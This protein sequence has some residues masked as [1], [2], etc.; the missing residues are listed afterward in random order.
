MA[1]LF[2]SYSR[3]DKLTVRILS[4]N[5]RRIYGHDNVWYD[6]SLAG[7]DIWWEEILDQI[8][9]CDVFLYLLS[10]ESVTSAYCQSE[11]AEAQRLHKRFI[12]IQIRG[13]TRMTPELGDVQYV[14]MTAGPDDAQ[15]LARLV[16]SINEQMEKPRKRRSKIRGRTRRPETTQT[17]PEITD[18]QDSLTLDLRPPKIAIESRWKFTETQAII[19]IVF[20]V[21]SLISVVGL[22]IT[23]LVVADRSSDI[24]KRVD[25]ALAVAAAATATHTPTATYTPTITQTPSATPTLSHTEVELTIQG[26]MAAIRS[27]ITQTQAAQAQGTI[28]SMTASATLLTPTPSPDARQLAGVRLTQTQDAID[29]QGTAAAL[30]TETAQVAQPGMTPGAVF[31]LYAPDEIQLGDAVEVELVIETRENPLITIGHQITPIAS[32]VNL[33]DAPP[34]P[35]SVVA[36]GAIPI[37]DIMRASLRGIDGD[38][39]TVVSDSGN[40]TQ[41]IV[42]TSR[43]VWNWYIK[44]KDQIEPGLNSLEVSIYNSQNNA[45]IARIHFGIEVIEPT[46][47]IVDRIFEVLTSLS[48]T[49]TIFVAAA[50]LITRTLSSIGIIRNRRGEDHTEIIIGIGPQIAQVL[51]D[52]G[53]D[54]F[55]TLAKSTED[56]LRVILKK[57]GISAPSTLPTWPAQAELAAQGRWDELEALKAKI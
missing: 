47:L 22:I 54:T 26:E 18:S 50:A 51:R 10:N 42:S 38:D 25:T 11:F 3:V 28:D 21:L 37:F 8:A 29:S 17:E 46:E 12:P 5:L 14:D 13:K 30:I 9:V 40:E 36:S 39:F 34:R 2:I 6:D 33:V 20:A 27:E 44:P 16:G 23:S 31:R 57:A 41:Q 52:S 24:P 48:V 15:A 56:D 53:I 32:P 49:V 35:M 55:A 4:D 1:R 45:E 43:N 7:G 19:M